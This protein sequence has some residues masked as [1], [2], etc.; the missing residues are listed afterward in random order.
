MEKESIDHGAAKVRLGTVPTGTGTVLG[1]NSS[2][3][4]TVGTVWRNVRG[5]RYRYRTKVV[6]TYLP[7]DRSRF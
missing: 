6:G 5:Y 2:L 1:D 4:G 3:N 7:I